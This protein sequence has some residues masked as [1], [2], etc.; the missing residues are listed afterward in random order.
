[1][2]RGY[3]DNLDDPTAAQA[4][5]Q[6]SAEVEALVP[7][8]RA[9]RDGTKLH[10]LGYADIGGIFAAK[11]VVQF[12][13]K[14]IRQPVEEIRRFKWRSEG[15]YAVGILYYDDTELKGPGAF[16]GYVGVV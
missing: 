4:V 8:A 13:F 14:C 9:V 5:S 1:L 12:F 2:D 11:A 15:D 6:I 16:K 10:T 7:A 3:W